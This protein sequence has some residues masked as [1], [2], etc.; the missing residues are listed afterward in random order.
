MLWHTLLFQRGTARNVQ[1]KRLLS[2]MK[3]GSLYLA[4]LFPKPRWKPGFGFLFGCWSRSLGIHLPCA[5]VFLWSLGEQL[6]VIPHRSPC[7]DAASG[8]L[9]WMI[10]W[11]F[12]PFLH[13]ES[14]VGVF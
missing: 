8:A 2:M 14:A 11:V 4:D 9:C 10:C 12:I 3:C 7:P 1:E 13:A 5:C 6:P